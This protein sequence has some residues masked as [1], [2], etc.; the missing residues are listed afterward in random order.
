MTCPTCDRQVSSAE[1][2]GGICARCGQI[3]PTELRARAPLPLV[4][5]VND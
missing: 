1:I 5:P 3:L 4:L 2:A